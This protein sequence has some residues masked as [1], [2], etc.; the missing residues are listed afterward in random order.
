MCKG[1]TVVVVEKAVNP[2]MDD[3]TEFNRHNASC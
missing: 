2:D 1:P 3:G